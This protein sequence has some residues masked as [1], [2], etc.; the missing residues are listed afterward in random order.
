M[1]VDDAD[2]DEENEDVVKYLIQATTDEI[3]HH[4]KKRARGVIKRDERRGW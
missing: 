4:D 1:D 2:E 3:I